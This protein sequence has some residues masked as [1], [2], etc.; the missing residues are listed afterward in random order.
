MK[1][2]KGNDR[3]VLFMNQY[4]GPI[5]TDEAFVISGL[6]QGKFRIDDQDTVHYDDHDYLETA[7]F[8]QK[9]NK[10]SLASFQTL[11]KEE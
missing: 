6:F 3:F 10:L 2:V 5:I 1:A 8:H 4:E 11:I 9:L 7:A